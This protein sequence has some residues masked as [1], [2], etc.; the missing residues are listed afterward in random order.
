M[1]RLFIEVGYEAATIAALAER[2]GLRGSF[3]RRTSSRNGSTS[4]S[5]R[6]PDWI[7]LFEDLLVEAEER[8]ELLPH[9]VHAEIARL[10][11]GAWTGVQLVTGA[12]G[13][14]G[15]ARGDSAA[16]PVDPAERRHHRR[17]R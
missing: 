16:L 17:P 12:A 9:T 8:G 15:P 5:T 6:W 14:P 4:G 7:S 10:V 1:A 11:V 13:E 2:T 3:R